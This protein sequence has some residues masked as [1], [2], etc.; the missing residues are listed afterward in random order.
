MCLCVRAHAWAHV[1]ISVTTC[2]HHCNP[3]P[4]GEQLTIHLSLGD[5][6]FRLQG[7]RFQYRAVDCYHSVVWKPLPCHFLLLSH[8]WLGPLAV[9]S[10]ALMRA[11]QRSCMAQGPVWGGFAGNGGGG[12]SFANMISLTWHG[13]RLS[14]CGCGGSTDSHVVN[15]WIMEMYHRVHIF[16]PS[17]S[18]LLHQLPASLQR[19]NVA[20]RFKVSTLVR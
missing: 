3:P 20:Y 10:Q 12:N 8:E 5:V 16:S 15:D 11:I 1:H 6:T 7:E 18:W 19:L 4:E 17:P 14:P 13:N 9:L 2:C